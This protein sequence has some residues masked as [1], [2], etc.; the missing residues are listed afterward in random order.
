MTQTE[1]LQHPGVANA[2]AIANDARYQELVATRSRFAWSL[3]AVMLAIFF[4]YILLIAFEPQLLARPI[5]SGVTS[6]GIPL[7]LGVI[8]AG[9]LLTALYVRRANKVFDRELE[10][11]RKEHGA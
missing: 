5:G 8:F 1:K 10:Q 2:A 9:I 6:I 3:T 4:G 7:G 11:L